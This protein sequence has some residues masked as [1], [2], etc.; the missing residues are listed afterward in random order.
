MKHIHEGLTQQHLADKENAPRSARDSQWHYF[1][2]QFTRFVNLQND[3][4]EF[5]LLICVLNYMHNSMKWLVVIHT[6]KQ[7]ILTPTKT[8][9][10]G[11]GNVKL[12][13]KNNENV[14][15]MMYFI[16]LCKNTSTVYIFMLS[17]IYV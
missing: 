7:G 15:R 17:L 16:L 12:Y 3:D 14:T 5:S 8:D 13:I 1:H 6:L 11:I 9:A 2:L 4:K 10:Y